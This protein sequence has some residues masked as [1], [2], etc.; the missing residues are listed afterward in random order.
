MGASTIQRTKTL[1]E[2]NPDKKPSGS[3][4]DT[5]PATPPPNNRPIAEQPLDNPTKPAAALRSPDPLELDPHIET[6]LSDL[7]AQ[8]DPTVHDE[9]EMLRTIFPFLTD[10]GEQFVLV[11]ESSHFGYA[12]LGTGEATR[13]IAGHIRRRCGVL[14]RKVIRG[15]QEQLEFL[16]DFAPTL[17][18]HN[19]IAKDGADVLVDL[20]EGRQA[21][22]GHGRYLSEPYDLPRF[23]SH[24]AM[25]PIDEPVATEPDLGLFE[26]AFGLSGDELLLLVAACSAAHVLKIAKPLTCLVGSPGAGKTTLSRRI[27]QLVDPT[28]TPT[29]GELAKRSLVQIFASRAICCFDNAKKLSPALADELCRAVT[30]AEVERRKL[31][32]DKTP[33][34]F[35]LQP[36]VIVNAIDL[37]SERPDFLDRSLVFELRRIESFANNSDLDAQFEERLPELRGALYQLT[38]NALEQLPN[39][40]NQGNE[41]LADFARHGRAVALAL[42]LEEHAFTDAYRRNRELAR[43]AQI[44]SEPWLELVVQHAQAYV[45]RDEA[46]EYRASELLSTLRRRAV[47]GSRHITKS[48]PKSPAW[49]AQKLRSFASVLRDRGV[50]V[51]FSHPEANRRA[52]RVFRIEPDQ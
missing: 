44:E 31:Y 38:A 41:R 45:G 43:Y 42:G 46:P 7:R 40:T 13:I 37:P 22:I 49:L 27:L 15:V 2:T 16:A 10:Q 4:G 5:P 30:G 21:R 24:P 25:L 47:N 48:L 28:R 32:T 6:L 8:F 29:L 9:V 1:H 3:T 17:P 34:L 18:L 14:D 52:V 36:W 19:R 11:A 20:R 26:R 39:V 23:R 33:V 12:E 35:M 50:E 51:E